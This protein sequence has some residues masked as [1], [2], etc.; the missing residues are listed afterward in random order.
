[1]K[2]K[3][4]LPLSSMFLT[5]I[6]WLVVLILSFDANLAIAQS[7]TGF[8]YQGKLTDNGNPVNT[9]QN[10][11]F[12]VYDAQSDGNL[13]AGPVSISSVP[14]VAGIFTVELDFGPLSP[15]I[16]NGNR[17][18]DI[19]V[20]ATTT[21]PRQHI[22]AAPN[23]IRSISA[24]AADT[25][26]NAQNLNSLPPSSY[27]LS[28]DSRLDDSR[29]PTSG[30]SFYIQNQNTA[31]QAANFKIG[32]DASIGGNL[33][34]TGTLGATLGQSV[35]TVYGTSPIAVSSALSL[36]TLVPGL[37][38]TISVPTN[39]GL[40]ISTDGGIQNTA[41]G[42]TYAAVDIGIFVDGVVS[43]SAGQR[44]VVAANTSGFGQMISN[45]SFAISRE[46]AAGNHTIEVRVVSVDPSAS[47]AN[48]SS[49]IS[50]Q[51]QGQLTVAVIR[52]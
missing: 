40:W 12:R 32:G 25:A 19:T 46:L 30:S 17:W 33:T 14:V 44:R 37:T 52:K 24:A 18:L 43:N 41:T 50:P 16:F 28:T 8:T 35:N 1:M 36:Y 34:V 47:T 4:H 42:S 7:G 13:I 11:S 39:S 31:T 9:P 5:R 26:V 2:H 38:Q 45:W 48:V 21:L 49:G 3:I 27:V 51:L 23:S 29:P 6:I 15:S 22:T 10:M 20:G